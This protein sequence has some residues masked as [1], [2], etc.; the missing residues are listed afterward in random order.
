[1]EDLSDNEGFIQ[2]VQNHLK[3]REGCP[4]ILI[5]HSPQGLEI[6]MNF[7]DYALQIGVLESA[8]ITTALTFERQVREGFKTG[9]NQMMVSNIKDMANHDKR[10]V[11]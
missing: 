11:N 4:A 3:E 5:I 10:K 9:E 6:Q 2:S 8:K 7:M 1:M